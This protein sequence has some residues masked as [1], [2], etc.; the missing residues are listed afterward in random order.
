[1]KH[2]IIKILVPVIFIFLP[3]MCKANNMSDGNGTYNWAYHGTENSF[4]K[5]KKP[6]APLDGGLSILAAAGIGYGIK[7]YAAKKKKENDV[8]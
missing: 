7:K 2:L 3:A 8:N 6:K 1:M 4:G 5:R